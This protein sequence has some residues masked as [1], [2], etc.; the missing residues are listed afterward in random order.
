MY[1][2]TC[3]SSGKVSV[4]EGGQAKSENWYIFLGICSFVDSMV[5]DQTPPMPL[6]ASNTIGLKPFSSMCLHA[7]KPLIP[8]PMMAIFFSI[9]WSQLLQ[10][11]ITII[12]DPE[13]HHFPCKLITKCYDVVSTCPLFLSGELFNLTWLKELSTWNSLI[14]LNLNWSLKHDSCNNGSAIW[15]FFS[16]FLFSLK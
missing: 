16:L 4:T 5:W 8:A 7:S 11:G 1:S 14:K 10:A 15:S 12:M 13:I 3:S 2:I 6:L 9:F